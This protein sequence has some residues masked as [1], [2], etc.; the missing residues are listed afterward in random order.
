MKIEKNS[1]VIFHYTIKDVD[2]SL[3]GNSNEDGPASYVHGY[4][5]LLPKLE[6]AL[7]GKEP[8]QKFDVSIEPHEGYGEH[9]D[10]L[11]F[12]VEKK[13]FH[14]DED[15]V[16]GMEFQDANSG[17]SVRV[18]ELRGDKVLVD[19]NH[20]F[21]GKPL[22]FSVTVDSVEKA[23]DAEIQEI[24]QMIAHHSHGCGCGCGCGDDDCEHDDEC[25]C[26]GCH[27]GCC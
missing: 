7:Q 27:G 24:Q 12:E 21:A 23:N 2:G 13:I 22:V 1:K 14:S 19:A 16:V 3:L 5:L 10:D 4:N 26:G 6:D 15:L 25:G 20:P 17:Q 18:V 8:G 9:V 11:V